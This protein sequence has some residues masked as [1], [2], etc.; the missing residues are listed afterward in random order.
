MAPA[1]G[2]ILGAAP[3]WWETRLATAARPPAARSGRM[4]GSTRGWWWRCGGT[5]PVA[6]GAGRRAR[7]PARRSRNATPFRATGRAAPR[8]W[9]TSNGWIRTFALARCGP[10]P[11]CAPLACLPA[12]GVRRILQRDPLA[13][14][15]LR[16]PVERLEHVRGR[17][18]VGGLADR[19]LGADLHGRP[20][21]LL[22]GGHGCATAVRERKRWCRDMTAP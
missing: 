20:A 10:R 15:G 1:P 5:V 4:S 11:T 2:R 8:V 12:D 14:Q 18:V 6:P 17:P 3:W 9:Q 21:H 16:Q 13:R 22:G 19:R 7:R